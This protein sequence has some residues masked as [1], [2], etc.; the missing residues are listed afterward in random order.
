ML[1]RFSGVAA[2]TDSMPE[3]AK[4]RLQPTDMCFMNWFTFEAIPR[5]S[6]SYSPP[7]FTFHSAGR[8]TTCSNQC[9]ACVVAPFSSRRT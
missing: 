4:N 3:V 8:P 7:S 2:T 9:L 6:C 5:R 1:F